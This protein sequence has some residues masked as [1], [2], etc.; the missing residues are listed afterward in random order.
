M[1][2]CLFPAA[3]AV[4]LTVTVQVES[5]C[6]EALCKRTEVAVL[7]IVPPVQ[8]VVGEPTTVSPAEEKSSIKPIPDSA[9]L[10]T[11]LIVMVNVETPVLKATG[12]GANDLLTLAHARLVSEAE[13]SKPF[14][15]PLVVVTALTG[16]VLVR[17]S[18]TFIET[19][20]VKVQ[21]ALAA[22]VPPL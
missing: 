13:V 4:K 5:L 10:P 20:I 2:F 19:A 7:V 22:R 1:Q 8:V 6:S 9:T 3:T 16:I 17:L 14:L 11:L 12:L 21:A 15:P 18:M